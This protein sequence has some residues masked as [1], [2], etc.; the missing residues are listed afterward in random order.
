MALTENIILADPVLR[1]IFF[2][3]R[4]FAARSKHSAGI[5]SQLVASIAEAKIQFQKETRLAVA[6]YWQRLMRA[7]WFAAR[8]LCDGYFLD[9]PAGH[10]DGCEHVRLFAHDAGD[11]A[12][13]INVRARD[14]YWWKYEQREAAPWGDRTADKYRRRRRRHRHRS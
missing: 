6:E 12:F 13:E 2:D 9:L 3:N 1:R 4:R 5:V 11:A 8:K 10:S 14:A 7:D